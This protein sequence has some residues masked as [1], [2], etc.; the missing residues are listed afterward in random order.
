M[1]CVSVPD[2]VYT[3]IRLYKK[4]D[5]KWVQK[6]QLIWNFV[7]STID[8][9]RYSDFNNDGYG[10]FIYTT[11]IAARGSN[12]MQT[13]FIFDKTNGLLRRI[14]NSESYPNLQYNSRLNCIDSWAFHGGTTTSFLSIDADSLHLFASVTVSHGSLEIYRYDKKGK[15]TLIQQKAYEDLFPRFKNFNPLEE[16]TE[17]DHK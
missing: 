6:Q 17:A 16:Y 10:D 13:L 3:Q 14:K 5:M 4:K 8:T 2:S 7:P 11:N 9:P 15:E 1:K 12:D